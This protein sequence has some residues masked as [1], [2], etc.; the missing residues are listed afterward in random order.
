MLILILMPTIIHKHIALK[1]LSILKIHKIPSATVQSKTST[2]FPIPIPFPILIRAKRI[3]N[4]NPNRKLCRVKMPKHTTFPSPTQTP[5]RM[6]TTCS[7]SLP[8]QCKALRRLRIC[9]SVYSRVKRTGRSWWTS[10]FHTNS[11][12]RNCLVRTRR[13]RCHMKSA[14][15][16][17]PSRRNTSACLKRRPCSRYFRSTRALSASSSRGRNCRSA[18]GSNTRSS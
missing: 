12:R 2:L 16:P 10:P 18:A 7:I 14:N 6:K 3:S 13:G 17:T 11:S 1:K 5:H 9:L 8:C 15:C 4:S